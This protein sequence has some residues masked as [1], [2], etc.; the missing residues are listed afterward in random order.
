MHKICVI[1]GATWDVLLLT[2][3]AK[4]VSLGRGAKDQALAFLYGAKIDVT[5][6]EYSFGGGAANVAVGLSRLGITADI[7]TRLGNDWRAREIIAHLQQEKVDTSQITYDY[8]LHSAASLIITVGGAHEHVAL[9][10]RGA[11]V[12]LVVK[13]DWIQKRY[14]WF[15]LTSLANPQ[16]YKFLPSFFKAVRKF[17]KKIFWNPG[18]L[19]LKQINRLRPLLKYLEVLNVNY[20]E[21]QEILGKKFKNSKTKSILSALLK[22]GPKIVI[23][24]DGAKGAY[25]A[26]K[27]QYWHQKSFTAKP[28]NTIGAGD[29]FGSG[30][31]AGLIKSKGNLKQAMLWGMANS[32]SVIMHSGAQRGLLTQKELLRFY[33]RYV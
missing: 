16:W 11:T 31:L 27:D 18:S 4:L 21:A 10:D 3:E 29:S 14:D 2:N 23:V 25:V 17:N 20:K 33:R 12:N 32:N 26:T 6:S 1:G 22:L 19:Q 15:Y 5:G 13:S 28:V 9:V 30:F 24:T 8:K 7:Y